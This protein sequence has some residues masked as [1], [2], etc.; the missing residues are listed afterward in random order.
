MARAR[1]R[2][3]LDFGRVDPLDQLPA[4]HHRGAG[5]DQIVDQHTRGCQ[6]G[7]RRCASAPSRCVLRSR[8]E[9]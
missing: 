3:P 7:R 4:S 2:G 6:G 8:R 1:S 5:S 9:S